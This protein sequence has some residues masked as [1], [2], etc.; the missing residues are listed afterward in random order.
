MRS[1]NNKQMID[2]TFNNKFVEESKLSNEQL[3][4]GMKSTGIKN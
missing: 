2:V 1:V 3:R 4:K